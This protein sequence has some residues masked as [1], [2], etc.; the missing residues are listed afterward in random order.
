MGHIGHSLAEGHGFANPLYEPTGPTA[1]V[2]PVYPFLCAIAMKLFGAYSAGA[3]FFILSLNSLFAA[4]T[5]FP[6]YWLTK[7]LFDERIAMICGWTWAWF[8]YS[9]HLSLDRIW[10]NTLSCMIAAFLWWLTCE[11]ARSRRL[12]DWLLWGALW[13]AQGL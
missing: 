9:I 8:P 3:V 11:L 6:V 5:C 1:E 12:R 7:R 10:E 4:L 13:G 2:A